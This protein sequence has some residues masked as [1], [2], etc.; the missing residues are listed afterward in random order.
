M[1]FVAV[2]IVGSV[3]IVLCCGKFDLIVSFIFNDKIET[4]IIKLYFL[5][6]NTDCHN[7]VDINGYHI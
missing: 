1:I 7:F 2:A 6:L 3:L 5:L 4:G